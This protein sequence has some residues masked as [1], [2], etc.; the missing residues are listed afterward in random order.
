LIANTKGDRRRIRAAT[1][2]YLGRLG[3]ECPSLYIAQKGAQN[4]HDSAPS[5]SRNDSAV[6]E[7]KQASRVEVRL[8]VRIGRGDLT[9][10]HHEHVVGNRRDNQGTSH[11]QSLTGSTWTRWSRCGHRYHPPLANHST[12]LPVPRI[13]PFYAPSDTRAIAIAALQICLAILQRR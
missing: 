1:V 2:A 5:D 13:H 3:P 8:R 10:R 12:R 11:R 7:T 6:H 4:G 9:A